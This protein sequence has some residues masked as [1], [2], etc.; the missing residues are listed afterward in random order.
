MP[1]DKLMK[2][3]GIQ[4]RRKGDDR[5][6]ETFESASTSSVLSVRWEEL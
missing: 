3:G 1:Q 5:R 2:V 6:G 4:K